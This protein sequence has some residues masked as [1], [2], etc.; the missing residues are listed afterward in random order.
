MN[1]LKELGIILSVCVAGEVIS[2][3][4][5]KSIPGNVLGMI[6]LLVLLISRFI[7][8]K[9]VEHVADFFLKNMAIFFVPISLGVLEIYSQIKSQ[10]FAIFIICVITTI[11]TALSTALTVHFILKLQTKKE[12]TK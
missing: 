9:Q 1:Y 8:A 5:N 2:V 11:L 4:I 12:K 10:I 3:L 7:K 6:L